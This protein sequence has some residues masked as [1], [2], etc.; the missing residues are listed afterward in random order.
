MASQPNSETRV[1]K[2]LLSKLYYDAPVRREPE[3]P[4]KVLVAGLAQKREIKEYPDTFFSRAFK[5][6][7]GE[8]KTMLKGLLFF[9]P[10]AIPFV[11]LFAWF[12]GYFET[13]KLSGIYNFV[14]N[15]GI[16]FPGGGDSLSESVA[17]LIWEI[18]EPVMLMLAAALIFGSLGLAGNFYLAKRSYFQDYYSKTIKTF[19][20]GFAKYWWKF[21][22]T[23]T[24]MVL[25]GSAMGTALMYL[26]KEQ[27]L[28]TADAGA[29][30]AVV[31]SWVFG[32]PLLLVP[33]V[34][35]PLFTSYEATFGQTFKNALVV[36][37]NN[38]ISV[39]LTALLSALPIVLLGIV[40]TSG[41]GRIVGTILIIVMLF[42]GCNL[43]AL[44]ITAMAHRG[45]TKCHLR[46]E[47]NQKQ[48]YQQQR[49]LAKKQNKQTNYQGAGGVAAKKPKKPVNTYKN[50]KKN[51][52]R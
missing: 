3:E 42:V 38:P 1:K 21:L 32:A 25:V 9:I 14:G 47:A 6:F 22:I 24:F 41:S 12:G 8:F 19:W 28:G 17:R 48:E 29:Y 43:Y 27:T 46:H 20:L 31:F 4:Q 26:L 39:I 2:L 10:F 18:K 36:I 13:L 49:K 44:S 7:A 37:V 34:M 15:I 45:M 35:L 30:C 16:G 5:V 52:K 40:G 23:I 51:K 11:I 50:P 33:F